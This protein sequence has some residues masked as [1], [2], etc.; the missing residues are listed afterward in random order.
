MRVGG[1][2]LAAAGGVYGGRGE[3]EDCGRG[4]GGGGRGFVGEE[5]ADEVGLEGL[6]GGVGC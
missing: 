6:G 1:G 3:G 4:E 2:E 5:E